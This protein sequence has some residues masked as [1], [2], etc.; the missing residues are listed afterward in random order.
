MPYYIHSVF[1]IGIVYLL[2]RQPKSPKYTLE[3]ART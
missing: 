1:T 2:S 3:N